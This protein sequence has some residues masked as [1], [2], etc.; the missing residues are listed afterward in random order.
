[1]LLLVRWLIDYYIM[2]NLERSQL[3]DEEE[4]PDHHN[5]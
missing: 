3:S 5:Q 1:M 2:N 4:I